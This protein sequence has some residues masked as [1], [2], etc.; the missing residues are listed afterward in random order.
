M[1]GFYSTAGWQA[2]RGQQLRLEPTCR[3][4]R[5]AGRVTPATV[6]DHI[7][8]HRG[9]RAR[10]FD[11][12]NLQSLCKTCHD[13]VKQAYEKSGHLKGSGLDGLPLDGTHPW[14]AGDAQ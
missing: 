6:A 3:L 4:C 10:F 2:L 14:F 9:D 8:P 7:E 13:G 12:A 5:Q 11:P 1:A